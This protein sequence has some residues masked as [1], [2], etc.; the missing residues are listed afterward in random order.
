MFSKKIKNRK[1]TVGVIGLGYVGLPRVLQFCESKIKVIGFDIDK[2]KISKLKK[3]ESYLSNV[4]PEKI[5]EA[6]NKNFFIPTHN[7][8]NIKNVDVIII[9]LP[10]PLKNRKIPDLS[11]I[12]KT[13]NKIKGYL[14]VNQILCLE[15]TSYPETTREI[16][17][18]TLKKKF[19]LGINFFLAYSPER[20]DPGL[21]IKMNSIPKIVSGYSPNCL[22][23]IGKVYKIIFKKIIKVSSIEIAEMTKI[24]E[25]VYRAINIGFVNE[26]KKICF[27]MKLDI[28]EI[29]RAAKSKPFGFKAF[30]PGPGLGGHCIP[31]DPF[32]LSWKAKKKGINTEFIN[33]AGKINNSMPSWVIEKLSKNLSNKVNK[34]LILGVAYK[35]NINDCRESPA[36]EMIRILKKN[37]NKVDYSDPFISKIPKLR[38]YNFQNMKSKKINKKILQSYDAVILVTDHDAFDYK[39]IKNN[40]KLIIDT[41]SRYKKKS[42]NVIFA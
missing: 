21:S 3:G 11:F 26:M 4:S 39:L 13:F 34:I 2:E 38:K 25:N 17:E 6:L 14:R 9:C 28:N 31:I 41:R 19:K 18:K 33:L 42:S 40:S 24:Y 10:T 22:N 1:F 7:F 29:I 16:F 12:K 27:K 30:Y 32:Y 15:S 23:L 8:Q 37:R 36:F 5:K 20:N 35:K